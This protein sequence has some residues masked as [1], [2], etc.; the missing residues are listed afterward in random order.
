[1]SDIKTDNKSIDNNLAAL[2]HDKALVTL[3][4]GEH[5]VNGIE[6]WG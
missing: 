6:K 4:N 1:M 2:T 3:K 5:L